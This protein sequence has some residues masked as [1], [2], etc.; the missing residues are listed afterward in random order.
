MTNTAGTTW[1]Y[2]LV[3]PS[4]AVQ[5]VNWVFNGYLDGETTLTWFSPNAD[6]RPSL[7]PL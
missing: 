5:S 3:V 1:E 2:S 6:W 7:I 4:N